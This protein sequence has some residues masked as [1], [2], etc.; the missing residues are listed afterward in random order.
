MGD[1]RERDD[2]RLERLASFERTVSR[3]A[4]RLMYGHTRPDP[5]DRDQ[6]LARV[7]ADTTTSELPGLVISHPVGAG[8]ERL[9]QR[10]AVDLRFVA[11]IATGDLPTG[12]QPWIAQPAPPPPFPGPLGAEKS[13]LPNDTLSVP[14]GSVAPDVIGFAAD[15]STQAFLSAPEACRALVADVV[16]AWSAEFIL[17]KLDAAAVAAADLDAAAAALIA[18][19]Y[20]GDLLVAPAGTILQSN[21]RTGIEALPAASAATY[22]I[23][24]SG[25]VVLV[26]ELTQLDRDLPATGDHEVSALRG[27]VVQVAAGAVQKITGP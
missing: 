18:A 20:P 17:S 11:G 7:V 26:G 10:R 2:E 12:S 3:A 6:R 1:L 23:G 4:T 22:L 8:V 14:G 5:E 27:I 25:V 9:L 13:E 16:A 19:G 24:H 21:A 15:F